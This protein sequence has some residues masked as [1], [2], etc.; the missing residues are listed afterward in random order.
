MRAVVIR[1]R[2]GAPNPLISHHGPLLPL[3]SC[4]KLVARTHPHTGRT[5]VLDGD[6][7]GCD[8]DRS[9][10]DRLIVSFQVT[11]VHVDLTITHILGCQVLTV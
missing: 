10:V 8:E 5:L 9:P 6:P 2:P 7:K 1:C 3:E 4:T 11:T